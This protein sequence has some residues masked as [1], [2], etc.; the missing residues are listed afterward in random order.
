MR[1]YPVFLDSSFLRPWTS[2]VGWATRVSRRALLPLP[3]TCH[4]IGRHR[5]PL[6]RRHASRATWRQAG[7]AI[8]AWGLE[9]AAASGAKRAAGRGGTRQRRRIGPER[10]RAEGFRKGKRGGFSGSG[11]RARVSSPVGCQERGGRANLGM[12]RLQGFSRGTRR[13]PQRATRVTSRALGDPREF[14]VQ[15][16]RE[17]RWS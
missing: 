9:G 7:G 8:L 13:Y 17:F 10:R 12:Q 4:S 1:V 16:T 5:L 2:A 6:V 15:R 3:P 14:S 11:D